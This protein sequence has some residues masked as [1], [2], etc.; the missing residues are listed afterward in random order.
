MNIGRLAFLGCFLSQWS[1]ALQPF[2]FVSGIVHKEDKIPYLASAQLHRISVPLLFK[3]QHSLSA[4]FVKARQPRAALLMIAGMQS[5]SEWH[6]K[7]AVYLA[8]HGITVLALDRRGSGHSRGVRGHA[9]SSRDLFNDVQAGIEF[10]KGQNLPIHIFGNCF[11]ARLVVPVATR[12]ESI[13]RSV[14][15][16]SPST[17]MNKKNGDFQPL[18]KTVLGFASVL[19]VLL[20]LKQQDFPTPLDDRAFIDSGEGLEWIQQDLWGLRKVTTRMLFITRKLRKTLL[21]ESQ[22]LK[23]PLLIFLASDDRIV[24]NEAIRNFYNDKYRGS[25]LQIQEMESEHAFEF[26]KNSHLFRQ[27]IRDWIFEIE[28]ES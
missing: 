27:S 21:K 2:R 24:D 23:A 19:D 16:S 13:I 15:L 4:L 20:P 12:N 22:Q 25:Y 11:G 9:G 1:V 6:R 26:S 7:T 28:D 8:Q 18:E 14:I 10:L 5:H 3:D 17:H